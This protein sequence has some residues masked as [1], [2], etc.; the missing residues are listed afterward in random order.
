MAGF[1]T[2]WLDL[3][4]PA[5]RRARDTGLA[6]DAARILAK[7]VALAVDLG[8]GTGSTARAL[9]PFLSGPIRWRL[10][11]NDP[12]LLAAAVAR[13]GPSTQ[14]SGAEAV[15]LDLT[16]IDALPVTDASLVTAS[17]LFDLCSA[18][19]IRRLAARLAPQ[20][21]GLYAALNY[22]GIVTW[23]EAHPLDG[24]VVA[25]FN[26]HQQ[27]DK[28]F[29]PALGPHAAAKLTE[30]FRQLGYAVA[31]AQ[32]PWILSA[33]DEMLQAECMRGM[34]GAVAE[35]AVLAPD[36][37]QAW[38]DWRLDACRRGATCHVGHVDILASAK[39]T[40]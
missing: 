5:D 37:L 31:E 38:L 18:D 14:C 13:L 21:I 27:T 10:V 6:R 23:D 28:G 30:S 32:S 24:E 9:S 26:R 8:C 34:A 19:F 1:D 29:G 16:Q 25:L 7:P 20:R 36:A 22:D 35:L 2:T 39:E 17:A 15:Q 40:H 11:D 33:G 12:R 4:E 3:R